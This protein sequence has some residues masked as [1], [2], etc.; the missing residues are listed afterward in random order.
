MEYNVTHNQKK[1]RFETNKDGYLALVEYQL[2]DRQIINIY[3]TE[4]PRPIEGQGVGSAIMKEV[5]DFARLN[6]YRVLPTCPFAQSYLHK[7]PGYGDVLS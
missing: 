5:L 6:R 7:H 3:H 2:L 1:H 4:V